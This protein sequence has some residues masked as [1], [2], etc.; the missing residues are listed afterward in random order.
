M[1][2]EDAGEE[3]AAEE[4]AGSSHDTSSKSYLPLNT[5]ALSPLPTNFGH[6]FR[7]EWWP[8]LML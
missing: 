6:K 7:F 2:E 4:R 1:E 5:L 8:L 3:G